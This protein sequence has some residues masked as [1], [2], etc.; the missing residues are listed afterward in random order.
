[1][2]LRHGSVLADDEYDSLRGLD[3]QARQEGSNK[4]V[5]TETREAS[6]M[7]EPRR[8]HSEQRL[9]RGPTLH[10]KPRETQSKQGTIWNPKCWTAVA[11]L[12]RSAVVSRERFR[13]IVEQHPRSQ[14]DK[15]RK[16][17]KGENSPLYGLSGRKPPRRG[18]MLQRHR[19]VLVGG[20]NYFV[21][22]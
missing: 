12:R 21:P 16:R 18:V 13:G 10:S 8:I 7:V 5:A 9:E 19:Q 14:E 20:W 3:K 11:R 4:L 2:P 22:G 1:M 15:R 6:H 17:R